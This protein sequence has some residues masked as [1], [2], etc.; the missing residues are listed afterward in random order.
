M[1]GLPERTVVVSGFSVSVGNFV[2][3]PTLLVFILRGGSR[4]AGKARFPLA[5]QAALLCRCEV[6]FP[7]SFLKSKEFILGAHTCYHTW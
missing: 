4:Q 3:F 6:V 2:K 1:R 5:L 7:H